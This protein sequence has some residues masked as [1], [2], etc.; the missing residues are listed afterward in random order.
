M[1][2]FKKEAVANLSLQRLSEIFPATTGGA[3]EM[4]KE[5]NVPYLG[6]LPVD[7]R[8]ARCCDQGVDFLSDMPDSPTVKTLQE[9]VGG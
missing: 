9:I 7:P 2:D 6:S 1:L 3:K 5:L 8:L 4:C